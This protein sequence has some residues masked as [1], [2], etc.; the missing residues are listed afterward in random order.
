MSLSSTGLQTSVL[1]SAIAA[2]ESKCSSGR[3]ITESLDKWY[4]FL[5]K[6]LLTFDN[7]E[8]IQVIFPPKT[9]K[10]NNRGNS[11]MVQWLGLYASTAGGTGS[12][13][14]QGS[15]ILQAAGWGQKKEKKENGNK[16]RI[17]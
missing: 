13:P 10:E 3:H 4:N 12:I 8:M 1:T 6:V 16:H 2:F 7:I 9:E 11:L 17:C 15:K 14:D 5:N